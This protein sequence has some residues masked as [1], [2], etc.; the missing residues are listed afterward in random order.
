MWASISVY[1]RLLFLN[2][3]AF[4]VSSCPTY[5]VLLLHIYV[6][7]YIILM[8][9]YVC[10]YGYMYT[11]LYPCTCTHLHTVLGLCFPGLNIQGLTP[12]LPVIS[13]STSATLHL[14]RIINRL[15]HFTVLWLSAG[16]TVPGTHC[17]IELHS[18]S[19]RSAFI[20]F[21]FFYLFVYLFVCF[22]QGFSV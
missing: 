16:L 20:L 22:R 3:C 12:A 21:L 5:P 19:P 7:V 1:N 18:Q 6:N 2:D 4:L 8:W 9:I 13:A 11:Y 10:L 14:L 17:T 15:N